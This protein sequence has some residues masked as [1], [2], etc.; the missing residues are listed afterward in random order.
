[1]CP[2]RTANALETILVNPLNA[3]L[4]PI[5]QLLSLLAHHILPHLMTN[6]QTRSLTI[7]LQI[8]SVCYM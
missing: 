3:E 2:V 1:M 5:C 4:N 6:Y 8:C 7:K